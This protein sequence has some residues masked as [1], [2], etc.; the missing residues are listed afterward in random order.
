M[1]IIA[2]VDKNTVLLQ[3]STDEIANL[4]GYSDSWAAQNKRG[5]RDFKVGDEIRVHEM[6]RRLYALEHR[7]G[8][9]ERL[10]KQLRAQAD[11]LESVEP[12]IAAATAEPDPPRNP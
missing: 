11:L 1:K 9:L 5:N 8:E 6:F 3:A 10:A 7:K 4:V 2:Q 12:V